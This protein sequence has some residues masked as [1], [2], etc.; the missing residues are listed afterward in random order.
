MAQLSCL[1]RTATTFKPAGELD[2]DALRQFLARMVDARVGVY[3]A[4]AGSGE[5]HSMTRDEIR[6][7][8]EIGV[9]VC[10]GKVQV[11]ANPPEQHSARAT[12]EQTMLAVESGVETVNVY[13][14]ASW[15]GFKP[16]ELEYFAYYDDVLAGIHH[17]LAIAPNPVIGYT[18]TPDA[19][20]KVCDKYHQI[21][22]VNLSGV[23][24]DYFIQLKAALKRSDVEIYVA[25]PDSFF[26]MALG[27]TG[28]ISMEANILPKTFRA[29]LDYFSAG[30]YDKMAPIY[31]DI[32]RFI[33]YVRKWQSSTPRW[34][35]MAMKI[36]A[37]PGGEGGPRE[38]YRMLPEPE[39]ENFA[40]GLAQLNIP[41]LNELLKRGRYAARE[42]GR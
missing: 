2:E 34:L 20:A 3:L 39:V 31:S 35:K 25:S 18:P 21:T 11:N 30:E 24:T 12:R 8:Y 41:E 1:C 5:S 28:M 42:P 4:S 40:K 15:H 23:G 27:A 13:G 19:I 10:K 7:V 29:Y 33:L 36:L 38:P 22:A 26:T 9:E 17:P 32:S 16:N 37:L 6:R 14:P